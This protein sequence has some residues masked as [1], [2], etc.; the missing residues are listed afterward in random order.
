VLNFLKTRPAPPRAVYL[1]ARHQTMI[2]RIYEHGRFE[3]RF[4]TAPTS[5]PAGAAQLSVEVF[6][7]W[8]E[9][10]LRVGAYGADL[11]DLVR[12]R[13]HELRLRRIDWIGLDLP[14]GDP[15][16]QTLCPQLEALGFFFAGII[17]ELVG[18][19]V[20]RMQY[21]NEVETELASVQLASDFA[22]ELFEY[23]SDAMRRSG[24]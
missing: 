11:V 21:L 15:A 10:S 13:L 19:D 17:P 2:Q 1:P 20:L 24:A 7:K 23:V 9:A 6:P 16:A 8:S 18:E 3:R 14:L 12:F 4:E 22:R 5:P